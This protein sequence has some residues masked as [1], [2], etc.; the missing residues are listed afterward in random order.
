MSEDEEREYG[1][2]LV[3]IYEAM[4]KQ[5]ILAKASL[6]ANGIEFREPRAGSWLR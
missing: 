6:A 2:L 5:H 4:I 1:Q 3:Q